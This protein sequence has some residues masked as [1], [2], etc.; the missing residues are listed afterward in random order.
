MSSNPSASVT[1]TINLPLPVGTVIAYM[2]SP[3]SVDALAPLGWLDCN[4]VAA[5]SKTYPDLFKVIGTTYGGDGKPDFNLPQ[6]SGAFLRG[7]DPGG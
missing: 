1:A 4:G 5:S 6:L 3:Q 2:G 7:V